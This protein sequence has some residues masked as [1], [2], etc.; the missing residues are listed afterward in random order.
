ME[1][2][3]ANGRY[4]FSRTR[5]SASQWLGGKKL[6]QSLHMLNIQLLVHVTNVIHKYRPHNPFSCEMAQYTASV[7]LFGLADRSVLVNNNIYTHIQPWYKMMG[8]TSC[9]YI[10]ITLSSILYTTIIFIIQ[11][12]GLL[13]H[14]GISHN[15]IQGFICNFFNT[16][17]MTVGTYNR[18]TTTKNIQHTDNIHPEMCLS[19]SIQRLVIINWLCHSF[20]QAECFPWKERKEVSKWI[21]TLDNDTRADIISWHIWNWWG[22]WQI[23]V[24]EK[25]HIHECGWYGT[26][27]MSLGGW[28]EWSSTWGDWDM[29]ISAWGGWDKWISTW[30]GWYARRG[31]WGV[32]WFL[33]KSTSVWRM[34]GV[35][36][37]SSGKIHMCLANVWGV[38]MARLGYFWCRL[39][40]STCVWQMSGGCLWRVW[41]SP[42]VVWASAGHL[43]WEGQWNHYCTIPYN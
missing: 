39:V 24:A 11:S 26:W 27:P 7:N 37:V 30:G 15:Q 21:C 32:I 14:H 9:L 5:A 4:R 1:A 6:H 29:W 16:W 22:R 35:L 34:S 19:Y 2:V 23:T 13:C 42:G 17:Y 18:Y 40:K 8:H 12:I 41:G 31:V 25:G 33:V 28:R 38:S 43:S 10:F 20:C 36:L 3:P